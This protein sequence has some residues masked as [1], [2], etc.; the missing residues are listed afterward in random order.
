MINEPVTSEILAALDIVAMER[1][2]DGRFKLLRDAPDWFVR[3]SGGRAAEET[4]RPQDAFIFLEHFLSEAEAFWNDGGNGRLKSGPWSETDSSGK[5]YHLEA[6]ALS[7]G[8]RR[9]LVIELLGFTYEEIQ[10]LAQKARQKS[11]DYERLARAEEALR[12]SETRNQALLDAIPDLMLRIGKQGEILD[13]RPKPSIKLLPRTSDLVRK[14]ARDYLPPDMAQQIEQSAGMKPEDGGAQIFEHQFE[15]GGELRDYE[16]RVVASGEEEA[17]AIVRDITKRKRLERELIAAREAALKAARVKSEFLATMSHEIRTPMNGVIGMIDLLLN[18]QLT[19]EQR[20]LAEIVQFSAD[21][22]L[23]IINDILDLSKIEAGKLTLETV[24]FE[25]RVMVERVAAI[26]SERAHEKQIGLAWIIDAGVET[27]LRGDPIRLGQVLT[28]LIGNAVKFTEKGLVLIRISEENRDNQ[29]ARL[30]FAVTDTGIGISTEAL[31]SLFQPFTQAD[32]ST[33]RKYGGTGL[34]LAISKQIA[35]LMNGEIGVESES[36]KGSTFWFVAPFEK[37]PG[38]VTLERQFE[39]LRAL[40]V[41]AEMA[42]CELIRYQLQSW[43][44]EIVTSA[45]GDEALKKLREAADIRKPFDVAIIDAR[46]CVSDGKS[47]VHTIKANRAISSARLIVIKP[48]ELA[49]DKSS[50]TE[51]IEALFAKP[52]KQSQLFDCLAKIRSVATISDPRG[53]AQKQ[54][55][56]GPNDEPVRAIS[57]AEPSRD[58]R[59]LVRILVAE[60]SAVNR[61]IV[62]MQLDRAGY[63]ADSVLNGRQAIEALEKRSYDIVLMDCQ[64]PEMDG[65]QATREIRQREGQFRRVIIIAMTAHALQGDREECLAAGMDDYISKP[66]RQEELA[67][68][69]ERWT[70]ALMNNSPRLETAKGESPLASRDVPSIDANMLAQ[71]RKLA[72]EEEP[73]FLDSLIDLFFEDARNHLAA[74]REGVSQS[75]ARKLADKSHALKSS[76]GNLGAKKMT[77]ICNDIEAL[78][79]A[80]SV[81]GAAALVA[82]LE[83]EFIGVCRALEA[84]KRKSASQHS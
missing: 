3:L 79:R 22:L 82:E 36:G 7:L 41:D 76:C 20:K 53:L 32:S 29:R 15:V 78:G 43:G 11:L 61:Q 56:D 37:Q 8:A 30:R 18:T 10:T 19:G 75:D 44:A 49:Y 55:A 50:E 17:L 63:K 58:A 39:K 84:E 83:E 68:V 52:V 45:S 21:S 42:S 16:L 35:E 33:T 31:R 26:F 66:L 70:S 4:I 40:V 34:G 25:L 5:F 80:A 67:R 60:D 1:R 9:L 77:A 24:D 12:K 48:R 59:Q 47:L 72:M 28:N 62:A 27:M 2:G 74:L 38:K 13:Y 57:L 65:Y 46:A 73:D 69:L 14:N 6:T 81:E 51:G 54:K 64:M 23:T 71:M